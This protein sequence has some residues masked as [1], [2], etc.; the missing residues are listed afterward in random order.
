MAISP[1]VSVREKMIKNMKV[2]VALVLAALFLVSGVVLA[3][4][5]QVSLR[6]TDGRTVNLADS[7]GKVVVLSFGGTWVPLASKELPVLQK[8][9]D[10]FSSRGVQVYWVSINSN[11]PG[12]RNFAT[13]EDIQAFAQKNNSRLTVLR[14]PEQQAYKGFGLDAVP[15]VL[16]LGRDGSVVH[17]QVGIGTEQGEGY[18]EIVKAL[19]QALK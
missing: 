12:A 5:P 4:A 9:A 11:K 8:V 2:K 10:R 1:F 18:A 14:D 16:I 6:S 7:K 17:K 3:Q 15:T 19:E 13:D